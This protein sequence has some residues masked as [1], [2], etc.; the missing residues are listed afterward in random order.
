MP[1][2]GASILVTETPLAETNSGGVPQTIAAENG[3]PRCVSFR[4][5]EALADGAA[6][7]DV[8]RGRRTC[9]DMA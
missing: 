6:G 4:E 7:L 5:A 2:P 8:D 1:G 9:C 3:R